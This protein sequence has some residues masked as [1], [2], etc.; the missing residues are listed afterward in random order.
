MNTR[1]A[2]DQSTTSNMPMSDRL[3]LI[4]AVLLTAVSLF[5]YANTDTTRDFL[6]AW[7]IANTGHLP[8]LGPQMAFS[9]DIG[10]WW[11]YL[12]SPGLLVGQ[13][14]LINAIITAILNASKFY[15]VY[16]IGLLV[17]DRMLGWCLLAG[18]MMIALNLMQSITFTHTNLVEP[19]VLW[20]IYLSL[21]LNGQ[22]KPMRW[23]FAGVVCGLAFHA[24]PT[25]FLAGFFVFQKWLSSERKAVSAGAF[26][27][28]LV[29]VFLPVIIHA[30]ISNEPMMSGL[31]TYADKYKPAL[32]MG[33]FLDLLAG[34]WVVGPFAMFKAMFNPTVAY[35]LTGLQ[36]LLQITAFLAPLFVWRST[37]QQLKT[38]LLN[39]W[40]FMLLSAI[41]LLLIRA[42]TPWYMTYIISLSTSLVTGIGWYLIACQGHTVFITRLF[43]AVMPL[44]FVTTQLQTTLHL[45]HST[46]KVP[47]LVLHDAKSFDASL[48]FDS[49][50]IQAHQAK[51]H[52]NYTCSQQPLAVHGPYSNLLFAHSGMEHLGICGKGLYYGP[53]AVSRHVI[54]VPP[55]F[56]EVISASALSQIGNTTFYEPVD[57]SEQQMAWE[58]NYQHDYQRRI[59]KNPDWQ[60]T[61]VKV[62]LKGGQHLLI[63]N[64]PG[65]KMP[66]KVISVSVNGQSVAAIRTHTYSSLYRCTDCAAQSAS[67]QVSYLEGS[68][69]MTNVVSF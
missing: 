65:F 34:I 18:L 13:S 41:G 38:L 12:L 62:E 28:G 51:A 23:L 29:L 21:Q 69:G 66:M 36:L 4:P 24:H 5:S 44:V 56:T 10:P 16:R 30:L 52:G 27:M 40:L 32:N 3:W 35:G 17:A 9:F 45:H 50:E 47:S 58:E 1:T 68:P 20:V 19:M 15:L 55:Q 14:W 22:S 6:M 39:V 43:L 67:W 59:K 48:S 54:G 57:I 64:L 37:G 46:L 11:F 61:E 8:L 60:S 26:L 25:A 7:Q 53:A 31:L 33:G 49:Y 2:P 63:T 42:N